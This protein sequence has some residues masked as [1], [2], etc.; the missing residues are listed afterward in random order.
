MDGKEP[1]IPID[2]K[3]WD[4]V[5]KMVEIMPKLELF[6]RIVNGETVTEAK[7]SQKNEIDGIEKEEL[8]GNAFEERSKGIKAKL[9]GKTSIGT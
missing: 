8:S 4:N 1:K 3:V 5:L 6:E 9:N 7:L 2:A